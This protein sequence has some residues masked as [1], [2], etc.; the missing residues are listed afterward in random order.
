MNEFTPV[1]AE[2]AVAEG[3]QIENP[4]GEADAGLQAETPDA[5]AAA[6]PEEKPAAPAETEPEVPLAWHRFLTHFYLWAAALYHFARTA[7]VFTGLAYHSVSARGAVYAG[8]PNMR[9]L[10]W[11]FGALMAVGALLLAISA[12]RLI[13]RRKNAPGMLF[14][15]YLVL[16]LAQIGYAAGRY[17]LTS[18]TP[19][20]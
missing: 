17:M 16:L 19:F 13:Q 8:L 18:L 5:Q 1:P 6:V 3:V 4:A 7:L 12:G 20:T 14:A 11:G 9:Y 15:A 10:D 2:E